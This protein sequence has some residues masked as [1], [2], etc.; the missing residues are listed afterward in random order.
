M[1][2]FE[3]VGNNSRSRKAPATFLQPLLS[4]PY[5][6]PGQPA[7]PK[8]NC[9]VP[10]VKGPQ[11]RVLFYLYRASVLHPVPVSSRFSADI[12]ALF[13][14]LWAVNCPSGTNKVF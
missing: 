12:V 11:R 14:A 7:E 6:I 5:L 10:G 2:I 1:R 4:D 3:V 9:F 13:A 8:V